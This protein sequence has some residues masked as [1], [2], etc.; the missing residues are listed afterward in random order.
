MADM[1]PEEKREEESNKTVVIAPGEG[2]KP[3]NILTDKNW[4]VKTFPVLYNLDG[5]NGMGQKREVYLTEQKFFE[6][7]ILNKDQRYALH[8][9]YI[10]TAATYIEQKQIRRN[11]Y[12]SFT[13]GHK[14]RN[15]GKITFEKND[16]FAMLE[17]IKGTPKYWQARKYE[18]LAKL[19][20]WGPFHW[21]FTLSCADKRWPEVTVT[22]LRKKGMEVK[23]DVKR[24]TDGTKHDKVTVYVVHEGEH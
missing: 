20:T 17:K 24:D 2:G 22:Y 19:E 3:T 23:V 11:E 4:D 8:P 9:E 7:R 16:A 6:Q 5:S 1:H 15:E 13:S 14:V 18:L 10:F 12:T 21:F